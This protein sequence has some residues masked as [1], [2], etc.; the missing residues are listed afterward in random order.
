MKWRLVLPGE[1][2]WNS[3]IR[4]PKPCRDAGLS[5]IGSQKNPL[6]SVTPIPDAKQGKEMWDT[7]NYSSVTEG[8]KIRARRTVQSGQHETF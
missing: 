2:L 6:G 5:S 8:E 7:Q 3:A 4:L 1:S